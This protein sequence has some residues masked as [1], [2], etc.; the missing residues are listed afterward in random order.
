MKK[1]ILIISAIILAVLPTSC[2][3]EEKSDPLSGK[4]WVCTANDGFFSILD[5]SR[6]DGKYA[7]STTG[8]GE[9][10]PDKTYLLSGAWE[11]YDYTIKEIDGVWCFVVDEYIY[12]FTQTSDNGGIMRDEYGE[13]TITEQKKCKIARSTNV[14]KITCNPIG[15]FFPA[16]TNDSGLAKLKADNITIADIVLITEKG[17]AADYEGKDVTGKFVALRTNDKTLSLAE[18]QS[19]ALAKGA[20][21][22]IVAI[23]DGDLYTKELMDSIPDGSTLPV[24]ILA[25]P[26]EEEYKF[27][28]ETTTSVTFSAYEL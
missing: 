1:I 4:T 23:W 8:M 12:K 18:K 21:G 7:W 24:F 14:V 25:E 10:D 11:M 9:F 16:L 6:T 27:L 19:V 15:R 20:A 3:K 2:K 17:E 13:F 26:F 5:L 22:L 28:F